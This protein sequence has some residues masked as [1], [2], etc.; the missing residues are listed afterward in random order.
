MRASTLSTG[1]YELA[2]GDTDPQLPHSEDEVYYVIRGRAV[3]RMAGE[4][5]PVRAGTVVFVEAGVDHRFHSIEED[6]TVLVV[7]APP[8]GSLA[9]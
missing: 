1:L 8:R 7:F 9:G 3:I 5:S 4:D 6:L 2:A